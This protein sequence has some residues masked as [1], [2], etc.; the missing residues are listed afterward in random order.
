MDI[1]HSQY[2]WQ[3]ED[4]GAARPHEEKDAEMHE[5]ENG[6]CVPF[7]GTRFWQKACQGIMDCRG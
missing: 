3:D 1:L 2:I 6:Q 7:I 4:N 5:L